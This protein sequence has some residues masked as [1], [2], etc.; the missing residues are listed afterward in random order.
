MIRVAVASAS[1][2]E[3]TALREILSRN[4]EVVVVGMSAD[5]DAAVELV[6][7][8]RPKVLVLGLRG[9]GEDSY[10][11]VRQIMAYEPTAIL[12][13]ASQG[14]VREGL[15]TQLFSAGVLDLMEWPAGAGHG[16]PAQELLARIKLLVRVP[17]ITHV[18]GKLRPAG[19]P[20]RQ[21]WLAYRDRQAVAIVASAGG[22]AALVQLLGALPAEFPAPILVVQHTAEGFVH[23]LVSWFRE[24]CS[25]RIEVA[26]GGDVVR[27]G[28]V[29]LAPDSSNMTVTREGRIALEGSSARVLPSGDRLFESVASVYGAGAIGVVLTG[30]GDD[31]AAGAILIRAA[32]GRVMAQDESSSTIFGMPRATIEAGAAD[33]VLPLGAIAGKLVEWIG[34]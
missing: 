29:L 20:F 30:M 33:V 9:P 16:L 6:A 12:A 4:P 28:L 2:A 34:P 31:G 24:H 14:Q 3:R 32:G 11:A 26:T 10:H 27:R 17:V 22:A 21:R 8:H 25:L 19:D 18:A 23:G 1:M 13:V 15:V 7:R 5:G